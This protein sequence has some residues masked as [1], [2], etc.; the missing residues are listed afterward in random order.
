MHFL[1]NLS[2]FQKKGSVTFEPL[3]ALNFIPN[4]RKIVGAIFSLSPKNRQ[5]CPK[6]A[7]ISIN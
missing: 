5:K 1:R 3:V 6:M 7:L 2:I 4:F